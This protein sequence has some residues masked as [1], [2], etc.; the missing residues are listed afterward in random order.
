MGPARHRGVPGDQ[1]DPPL[2]P[3]LIQLASTAAAPAAAISESCSWRAVATPIAPTERP[4]TFSGAPPGVTKASPRPLIARHNTSSWV[5]RLSR[6]SSVVRPM[7][8]ADDA[9][10]S[11]CLMAI[12]GA[13]SS[14]AG[15]TMPPAASVPAMT[16]ATPNDS[17]RSTAACSTAS[18]TASVTWRCSR[19]RAVAWSLTGAPSL[20]AARDLQRRCTSEPKTVPD[21]SLA[22]RLARSRCQLDDGVELDARPTG[23]GRDADRR[24]GTRSAEDVDHQLRGAVDHL[25]H[26][27]VARHRPDVAGEP[28]E[29][30]DAVE[31]ANRT[32]QVAEEADERLAGG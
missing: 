30:L 13:P 15:R 14:R 8:A 11:A 16:A 7:P 5:R 25:G 27:G 10:P 1:G 21:G 28:Q 23:Q 31:R 12:G 20:D 3:R 19:T 29:A 18:A 4:S 2:R 6:I 17:A 9:L 32:T 24:A 26:L 22:R